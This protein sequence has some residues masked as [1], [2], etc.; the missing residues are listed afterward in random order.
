MT[1]ITLLR[2][3]YQ[4][5]SRTCIQRILYYHLVTIIILEGVVVVIDQVIETNKPV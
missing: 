4:L 2:T 1:P 5:E 3:F